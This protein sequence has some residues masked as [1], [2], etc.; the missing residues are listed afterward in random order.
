MAV[1]VF[2]RHAKGMVIHDR[3]RHGPLVGKPLALVQI[4]ADSVPSV[5]EEFVR[6]PLASKG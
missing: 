3:R 4:D 5:R 2:E 1:P 6:E